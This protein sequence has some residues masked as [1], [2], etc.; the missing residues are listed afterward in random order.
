MIL[1]ADSGS[2]KTNWIL[3]NTKSGEK[4][5]F[6]TLGINPVVH[7]NADIVHILQQ[8][9]ELCALGKDIATMHFFGAGCSGNDRN[10]LAKNAMKQ[11]FPHADIFIAEDMIAAGI[12]ICGGKKGIACILG[13]GSNSIYFDGE[14][15]QT[16]NAGI[17]FILGDEG[18]GAYFGK[19]LLKDFLYERL[20]SEIYLYLKDKHKLTKDD[21][22]FNVYK[23]I[24]PNRYL[25]SFAPLLSE[26]RNTDYVQSLLQKGFTNFFDFH[27]TCFAEY[28]TVPVGFV[29][30]I[31][32][33][34]KEEIEKAAQQFDIQL[35]KFVKSP[36]DEVADYYTLYII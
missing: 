1:F 13:T 15:W 16:S 24:S 10:M 30:S 23:N 9:K 18:S 12:A 27:V 20:P 28:Q 29:G 21:I 11:I 25:A 3:Y 35:G 5:H 7:H 26:F 4:T 19:L 14:Q 6:S 31:A 2:T 36:V 33:H 34:F 17:G 8:N 32:I 22:F